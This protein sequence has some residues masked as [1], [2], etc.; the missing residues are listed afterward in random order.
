MKVIYSGG[1]NREFMSAYEHYVYEQFGIDKPDIPN[2]ENYL[3]R[4]FSFI[5]FENE[6]KRYMIMFDADDGSGIAED[7]CKLN[8]KIWRKLMDKYNVGDY[9]IFKMQYSS[10]LPHNA[11]YPFA[12]KTHPL[13]YFPYFPKYINEW[14]YKNNHLLFAPCDIDF[15]WMGTVNYE[16]GPPVWPSGLDKKHWQLGQRIKG[17]QTINEI[18]ERRP[19][20]NIVVSSDRIPYDEYLNLVMRTKVCLEIPGVGNLTTR[21]FENLQL[22]RCILGK[23]IYLELPYSIIPN[24]HYVAINEWEELEE[25]MD[26]L[27]DDTKERFRIMKNVRKLSPKLS[28]KYAFEYMMKIINKHLTKL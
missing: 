5:I 26:K 27:V 7:N 22:G 10:K 11:F 17:F 3:G 23:E 1:N 25:A 14:Q 9:I 28:Y 19:D 18:K 16:D 24:Q 13:G 8:E 4:N 21:F 2:C 6:K 15:L 12:H 20:L